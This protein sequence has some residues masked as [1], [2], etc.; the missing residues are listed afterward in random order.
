MNKHEKKSLIKVISFIKSEW[1]KSANNQRTAG[2]LKERNGWGLAG[3][4]SSGLRDSLCAMIQFYRLDI[5]CDMDPLPDDFDIE[6]H[7]KEVKE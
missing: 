7:L 4:R 2:S 1:R 5:P 6:N 3:G